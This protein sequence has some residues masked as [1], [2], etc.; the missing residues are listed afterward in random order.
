MQIEAM[1][2]LLISGASTI[3]GAV[4]GAVTTYCGAARLESKRR[5]EEEKARQGSL[6]RGLLAEMRDNPHSCAAGHRGDH[7]TSI[8]GHRWLGNS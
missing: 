5:H 6:M 2:A 3:L 8:F 1:A 7:D 4:I